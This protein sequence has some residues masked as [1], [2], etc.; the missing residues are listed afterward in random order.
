MNIS[1][2]IINIM[3]CMVCALSLSLSL[4]LFQPMA[5]ADEFKILRL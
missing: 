5:K 4:S 1:I 2:K 3:E